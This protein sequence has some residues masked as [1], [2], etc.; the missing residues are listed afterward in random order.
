MYR[1]PPKWLLEGP[2]LD[3]PGY[4]FSDMEKKYAAFSDEALQYSIKDAR[5][6]VKAMRSIGDTVAENWYTDDAST[7][8]AEIN[9]RKKR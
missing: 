9:R 4:P 6:A 3:R 1:T 7:I 2:T 8:R 5:Q